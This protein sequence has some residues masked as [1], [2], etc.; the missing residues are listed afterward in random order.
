MT[1]VA[2]NGATSPIPPDGTLATQ[3]SFYSVGGLAL[4]PVANVLYVRAIFGYVIHAVNLA[5]T[6]APTVTRIAGRGGACGLGKLE[7]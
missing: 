5:A 2:G 6:P 7:N 1:V 3:A 4:D